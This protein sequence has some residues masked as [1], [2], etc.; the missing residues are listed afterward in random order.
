MK[1]L[2][3]SL[4]AASTLVLTNTAQAQSQ[5]G[6]PE[7]RTT[8]RLQGFLPQSTTSSRIEGYDFVNFNSSR[9]PGTSASVEDDYGLSGHKPAFGLAFTRRLGENWRFDLEYLEQRRTASNVSLR[10]DI[11]VYDS[12]Y[13]AGT[14]V[15]TRMAFSAL[16][17]AGGYTLL[18][19]NATEFGV[20]FGGLISRYDLSVTAAGRSPT[21]YDDI[22]PQASVGLFLSSAISP[23]LRLQGRV[24]V[25]PR[26]RQMNVGANWR[27][28]AHASLGADVRWMSVKIEQ[29]VGQ[30]YTFNNACADFK[31][32]GPQLYLEVGF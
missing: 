22:D 19:Q 10:R 16:R 15:N 7:L 2:L 13:P 32:L 23:A 17:I 14:A 21:N 9:A 3:C 6:L 26:N 8:F 29:S 1:L 5:P 25:G 4:A 27:F 31:L 12:S 24:E 11:Q 30:L 28:A 18:R 20:S